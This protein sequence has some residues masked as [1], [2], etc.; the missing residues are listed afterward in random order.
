MEKKSILQTRKEAAGFDGDDIADAM[1]ALLKDFTHTLNCEMGFVSISELEV[2]MLVAVV[3]GQYDEIERFL[4]I[5]QL[6]PKVRAVDIATQ[7]G[8][9]FTNN[10][11]RHLMVLSVAGF[12]SFAEVIEAA[13]LEFVVPAGLKKVQHHSEVGGP[14]DSSSAILT[15]SGSGKSP[16]P[17]TQKTTAELFAHGSVFSSTASFKSV[18][19]I[20]DMCFL[21]KLRGGNQGEVTKLVSS[22]CDIKSEDP[23]EAFARRASEA[24][25]RSVL[26]FAAVKDVAAFGKTLTGYAKVSDFAPVGSSGSA[27]PCSS[28][29]EMLQRINNAKLTFKILADDRTNVFARGLMP[30]E[31]RLVDW[32]DAGTRKMAETKFTFIMDFVDEQWARMFAGLRNG[33][34]S[35]DEDEVI[36]QMQRDTAINFSQLGWHFTLA[37]M[38]RPP[39]REREDSDGSAAAAKRALK[40]A[41]G[42][43]RGNDGGRGRGNAGGRGGGGRSTGRGGGA[44]ALPALPTSSAPQG[45]QCVAHLSHLL[46]PA[47]CLPC[48]KVPCHYAHAALPSPVTKSD[49]EG[50]TKLVSRVVQRGDRRKELLAHIDSLP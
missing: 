29:D 8:V 39:K 11:R 1:F 24:N 18:S 2:G 6:W 19:R 38:S 31:Q 5:T 16:T 34:L 36:H 15:G 3:Q 26:D 40:Q 41:G 35:F 48:S 50:W 12:E 42:G 20:H 27:P 13:N 10:G 25:W 28:Y 23:R 21:L 43:G 4:Y 47:K 22:Q 7:E 49:K 45:I 46:L 33:G 32:D 14:S 44:A 9:F 30:F 17:S 37:P